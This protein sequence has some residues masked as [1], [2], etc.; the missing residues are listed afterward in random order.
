MPCQIIFE[1]EKLSE[2]FLKLSLPKYAHPW[3]FAPHC[4]SRIWLNL[5]SSVQ[6][7]ADYS[8]FSWVIHIFGIF[9]ISCP[10]AFIETDV[11]TLFPQIFLLSLE[12]RSN[13]CSFP[14]FRDLCQLTLPFKYNWEWPHSDAREIL[15]LSPWICACLL[16]CSLTWS[17]IP[18]SMSVFFQTFPLVSGPNGCIKASYWYILRQRGHWPFSCSLS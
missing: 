9:G 16:K 8:Q 11:R 7:Q 17:S 4:R 13:L 10:T 3:S 18:E 5:I 12:D 14:A 6:N 1:D 2:A 15:P